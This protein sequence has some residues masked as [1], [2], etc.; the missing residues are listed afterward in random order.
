MRAEIRDQ[1]FALNQ[2]FYDQTAG[3]F[4]STRYAIQPGVRRL[5]PLI[6]NAASVLD[7]GAGNGNLAVALSKNNHQ[8]NYLGIEPSMGLLRFA[9]NAI[10]DPLHFSFKQGNFTPNGWLPALAPGTADTVCA[11]AVL[12][13]IPSEGMQKLFFQQ[14]A[15]A[16]KPGGMLLLSVWQPRSS[17]KLTSR[18][19]PWE[20]AGFDP[21]D[22][23]SGDLLLDWRAEPFTE[24]APL[25]YVREFNGEELTDLGEQAGLTL[26]ETFYSDGKQ[27]N[28]ALYQVWQR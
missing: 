15:Q 5:L 24:D 22:F 27:G 17:E 10:R 21:A 18:I 28:L 4:A 11:F 2:R 3:S 13:H 19:V 7:L 8:G 1:L 6:A 16:L 20:S 12:H 25:R 14:A 23:E 9:E 26:Q